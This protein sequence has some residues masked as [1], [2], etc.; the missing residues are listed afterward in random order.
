MKTLSIEIT[1][2]GF[3]LYFKLIV[4]NNVTVIKA[5]EII[6]EKYNEESNDRTE[7]IDICLLMDCIC[8]EY[9]WKWEDF[10]YDIELSF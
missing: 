7:D 2:N 5:T 8:D 10:S 1:K 9:G 3:P 4:S 6:L